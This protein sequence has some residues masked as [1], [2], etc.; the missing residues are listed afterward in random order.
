VIPQAV[1]VITSDG[2]DLDLWVHDG[3]VVEPAVLPVAPLMDQVWYDDNIMQRREVAW[4]FQ[5][6]APELQDLGR[7]LVGELYTYYGLPWRED[8]ALPDGHGLRYGIYDTAGRDCGL[9][10]SAVGCATSAR[11]ISYN[12]SR[13]RRGLD[14]PGAI[15]A[16]LAHELGHIFKLGHTSCD[17]PEPTSMSPILTP[18]GPACGAQDGS[19]RFHWQDFRDTETFYRLRPV[20][21]VPSLDGWYTV[22]ITVAG[23]LTYPGGFGP[24]L[25]GVQ[26]AEAQHWQFKDDPGCDPLGDWCITKLGGLP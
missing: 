20:A 22:A 17:N 7:G 12:G 24:K 19:R 1:K 8:C 16:A 2:R 6:M 26:A 18:D 3:K 4:C 13:Y 10:D 23:Q 9:G 5:G 15:E 25:Q 14:R 11:R 21:L